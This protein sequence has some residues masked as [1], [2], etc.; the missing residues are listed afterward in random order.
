[1]AFIQALRSGARVQITVICLAALLAVP[2]AG[3]SDGSVLV[4]TRHEVTVAG[5]ILEYSA[6]AGLLP[7]RHNETGEVLGDVFFT[8]YALDQASGAAPRPITFLWNGGPGANSVLVHLFGFGPRRVRTPPTALAP[9]GCDCVMEANEGSWLEFTDLV[10]VD[11]IGTGFSRPASADQAGGFYG[12]REDAAYIAEFVRLFIQRFGAWDAPL[13]IGGESYGTWRAAGV[14]KILE[15]RGVSVDGVLLIS[16][17]IPVGPVEQEEMRVALLLPART[18]AAFHHRRLAPELQNDLEETLR[19]TEEWATEIYAPALAR[20][21]ALGVEERSAVV[22]GLAR[23]TGL[24][25]DRI[26]ADA[27]VVNRQDFATELLADEGAELARFDTRL[28]LGL[29]SPLPGARASLVGAYLREEL[30]FNSEASYQGLEGGYRSVRDTGAAGPAQRWR[31]NH[32]VPGEPSPTRLTVGD[33]PPGARPSW[34]REA[35][36]LDPGIKVFVATGHFDSLNSCSLNRHLAMSLG[37]PLSSNFTL[38]CYAGGH[39]MYNDQEIRLAM[40]SDVA[41]FV[42]SSAR[43]KRSQSPPGATQQERSTRNG[44]VTT[45]HSMQL[46]GRELNY[47]ARAGTLPIR[48]NETGEVRANVFFVAY[49]VAVPAGAP[50]R[51][52][53]FAWNGG[54]GSNAGLLHMM[55][56]GPRRMEMGDVY[57]TAD[58]G[59][60]S[61]L[62]DNEAT[63]LGSTDLVFVDPVGTGYS[64]PTRAEFGPEFYDTV[65]DVES[66]AE[67]VRVYR[68]RFGASETPVV[69]AG[70]SYG[71]LRA[72]S[73]ARALQEDGIDVSGLVLISGS[74]GLG[75]VP[76]HLA[77]ALLLPSLTATALYHDRLSP[78]QVEDPAGSLEEAQRW[79][80]GP[81]AESLSRA[82]LL[83]ADEREGVRAELSRLTGLGSELVDRMSLSVSGPDFTEQL[84]FDKG[85][86]LGRYDARLSRLRKPSEDM[87]DP[88]EDASLAPLGN[89]LS[90]NAPTM[91]RYLRD[92]LGFASDLYYI[93]PF[94]GAWPP[95]E[96]F[97]G[98]W[99][100]VRWNRS[101]GPL[102]PLSELLALN[103]GLRV[104]HVSGKYDLVTPSGPP[105]FQVGRLEPEL[106]QRFTVRVYEGGHSFYLDRASRLQFMQDGRALIEAAVKAG[107]ARPQGR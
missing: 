2:G 19:E 94:G 101:E 98:D 56:M 59:E 63:W 90:G 66:L 24:P 25:R 89:N 1:V 12:V 61:A 62:V 43:G 30:G 92:T 18:A 47:V 99:M 65:G 9:P 48:D 86:V 64:R 70:E 37:P 97:R 22:E 93:G 87:F 83:T 80:L 95:P 21:D 76:E 79:A 91:I 35:L 58:P 10:F 4:S 106:R 68:L 40:K 60:M 71:S 38:A 53:M 14:T 13:F 29:P 81:Y 34:L 20:R 3:Q 100:S 15:E 107:R 50:A 17:G 96:S 49:S 46:G 88:R 74:A 75:A 51:P 41:R 11:P 5:Q 77:P 85:R 39:V 27:L 103:P 105:A 36:S 16:G 42:R 23:Y 45:N 6:G 26:D 28:T 44:V 72:A 52:V 8:H 33:G 69:L 67:F 104:L 73:V 57:A 82:D 102:A 54:P 78:S 32:G 31:Y 7:I 55:A 84:L